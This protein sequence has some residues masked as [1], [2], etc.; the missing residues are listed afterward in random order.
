M[1]CGAVSGDTSIAE[2]R[3]GEH[4]DPHAGT[5][6]LAT[7]RHRSAPGHRVRGGLLRRIGD[8]FARSP[9]A[10]V[11]DKAIT[12]NNV[13]AGFVDMPNTARRRRRHAGVIHGQADNS[14]MRRPGHP[15]AGTIRSRA[16]A[17]AFPAADDAGHITGHTLSVNVRTCRR[18][19]LRFRPIG[20]LFD[21]SVI[22][23][24]AR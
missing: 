6:R 13:P 22:T 5:A 20:S 21:I 24:G 8:A 18:M 23:M 4:G 3:F 15:D 2:H 17:C 11:A 7:L 12:V 19:S 1:G 10:E 9:A 14:P 16:A